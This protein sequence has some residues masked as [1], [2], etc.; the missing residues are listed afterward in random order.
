MVGP[1]SGGCGV[2]DSWGHSA[3]FWRLDLAGREAGGMNCFVTGADGFIGSHLC[4]ALRDAGHEVT[5]L[6][7]YNSFDN[8][9]WLDEVEGI[10]K[11]RGDVRDAEQMRKLI[12]GHDVVFHLAALISV[13]YSFE[14]ASQFV[15]T[16]V[17]GTTNMLDA[18]LGG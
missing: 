17:Q 2:A 4:E 13:P 18:A 12:K 8:F 7:L 14:S 10:R 1:A 16:N 11:V 5:G 3:D 9:G 6:A 15:Q